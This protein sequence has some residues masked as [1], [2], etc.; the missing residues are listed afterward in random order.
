MR[1][2]FWR[3]CYPV[4]RS[5]GAAADTEEAAATVVAAMLISVAEATRILAADTMVAE[6]SRD[7][8][9]SG[10]EVLRAIAPLPGMAGR[11]SVKSETPVRDTGTFATR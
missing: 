5:A 9:R 10:E 1:S 7:P 2:L 6:A 11:I 4:R 3:P 8:I